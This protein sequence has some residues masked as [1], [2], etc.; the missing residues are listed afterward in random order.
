M[1]T[2]TDSPQAVELAPVPTDQRIEALDVVRGFALIGI[3]L[4]NV[5]FFNRATGTVGQGM[6][7]GLTVLTAG[8]GGLP[9]LPDIGLGLLFAPGAR[10][11]AC[12]RLTQVITGH[13]RSA[14]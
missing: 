9:V 12:E 1:H 11:P 4:M 14:A 5:E 2:L 8:E 6:P 3:C 10:T 13:V 7:A